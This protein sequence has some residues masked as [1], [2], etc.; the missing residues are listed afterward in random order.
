M[1]APWAMRRSRHCSP[2][3]RCAVLKSSPAERGD[4]A[5]HNHR[6]RQITRPPNHE[7][8]RAIGTSSPSQLPPPPETPTHRPVNLPQCHE[9]HRVMDRT[10]PDRANKPRT[11]QRPAT[12]FSRLSTLSPWPRQVYLPEFPL[13]ATIRVP[14]T[15]I[16]RCV[17]HTRARLDAPKFGG[18]H[19]IA[20]CSV[21]NYKECSHA[22]AAVDAA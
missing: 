4:R 14:V 17:R 18:F 1:L 12:N 2:G 6:S 3:L 7:R 5:S 19:S 21:G 22:L 10:H 16:N 15:R 20:L 11:S 8:H 9:R 13:H